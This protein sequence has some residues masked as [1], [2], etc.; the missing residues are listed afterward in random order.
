[1]YT[2]INGNINELNIANPSTP[3]RIIP[4]HQVC[5]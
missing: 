3:L 4:A 2:Y 5:T 1:M